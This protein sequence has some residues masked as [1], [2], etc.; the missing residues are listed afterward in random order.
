MK[1]ANAMPGC[2]RMAPPSSDREKLVPGSPGE[3]MSGKVHAVVLACFKR[4]TVI[5]LCT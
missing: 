2:L 1:E 5:A 4:D 3:T